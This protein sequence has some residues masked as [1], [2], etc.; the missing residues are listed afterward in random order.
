MAAQND[1]ELPFT[2]AREPEGDHLIKGLEI[3]LQIAKGLLS[4]SSTTEKIKNLLLLHVKVLNKMVDAAKEDFITQKQSS[5]CYE[6]YLIIK[7][8]F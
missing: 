6:R 3:I 1:G 8:S 5:E 2:I 4:N 7:L